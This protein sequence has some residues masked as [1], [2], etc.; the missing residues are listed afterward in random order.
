MS[1]IICQLR[2]CQNQTDC[3][4]IFSFDGKLSLIKNIDRKLLD[5]KFDMFLES[6]YEFIYDH[7]L[8]FKHLSIFSSNYLTITSYGFTHTKSFDDY[9]KG[10]IINSQQFYIGNEFLYKLSRLWDLCMR[11][12]IYYS[13]SSAVH[14]EHCGVHFS[15]KTNKYRATIGHVMSDDSSKD[16]TYCS[17]GNPANEGE[18]TVNGKY[19]FWGTC[20]V[21]YDKVLIFTDYAEGI[22]MKVKFNF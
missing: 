4:G 1:E 17:Y 16:M 14:V 3:F 11:F 2:I 10:F 19:G 22:I 5:I 8:Q 15:S 6:K 9:S 20:Y 12:Y 18:F 7:L 21:P 13:H